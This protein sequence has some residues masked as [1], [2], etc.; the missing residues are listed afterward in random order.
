MG[1]NN[2]WYKYAI[3]ILIG[4]IA[5]CLV[6]WGSMKSDIKHNK[7][8][9]EKRVLKTTFVEF[10]EGNVIAHKSI[11]AALKRIEDNQ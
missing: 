6:A 8:A 7:D 9:V 5:P 1:K 10:K 11:L 2:G 3:G 4:T